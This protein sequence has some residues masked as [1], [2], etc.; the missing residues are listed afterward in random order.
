MAASLAELPEPSDA[1]GAPDTGE[2]P[3]AGFQGDVAQM[4]VLFQF[5]RA[6]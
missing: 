3:S 1:I 5:Y 4:P 2:Y 6:G